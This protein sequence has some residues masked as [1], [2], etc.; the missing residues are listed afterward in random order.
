MK[1]LKQ[2]SE[3]YLGLYQTSMIKLFCKN[4]ERVL[5]VNYFLKKKKKKTPSKMFLRV[6]NTTL[7][8]SK[9]LLW[10]RFPICGGEATEERT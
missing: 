4:N 6:L 2:I 7:N 9:L 3:P 8:L 5:V 1:Q 10:G